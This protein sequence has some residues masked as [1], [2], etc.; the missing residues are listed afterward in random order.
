M[1]VATWN[2]NSLRAHQD[3]FALWVAERQPDVICLQET[4]VTDDLF[5]HEAVEQAGYP[6]RAV[7]GQ[8]TYNGVAI[9]SKLP[10][11]DVVCGFT[12][13]EPDPQARLIRATV[14]GVRVINCYAP[15][16]EPIGTEK[17]FY[18]LDWYA[19]LL[20]ELRAAHDPEADTLLCGDLNIA[21]DDADVY[22]PFETAGSVLCT[23]PEREALRA[24]FSWGL[25]DAY[26]KKNPFHTE[27][28]WWNYQGSAF[29]NNHGFRID[30][31]L[32]SKP[33]M[34]RCKAVR[35]DRLTRTW[36]KPSDHA[37]VVATLRT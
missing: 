25:V 4:K 37:P 12:L 20:N 7:H 6:H 13:G 26:R 10:L 32:L 22:D 17:F 2:V 31:V 3:H 16:G 21:P 5:P 15:N 28:S 1:D 34:R 33:L 24:L 9:L 29:R 11:E 30:H 36:D 14:G 23:G 27:F 8:K 18:K 35:I 19:R